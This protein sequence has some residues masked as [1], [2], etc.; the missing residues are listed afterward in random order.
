MLED[1]CL[2]MSMDW[3]AGCV[4]RETEDE[5]EKVVDSDKRKIAGTPCSRLPQEHFAFRS[6]GHE[7]HQA[8]YAFKEETKQSS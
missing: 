5:V 4:A 2:P 3:F 7:A 8:Q 6:D 1:D